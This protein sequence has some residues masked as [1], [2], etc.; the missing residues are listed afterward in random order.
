MQETLDLLSELNPCLD[1]SG[2]TLP[3]MS[4]SSKDD[5]AG[6]DST[7]AADG[8]MKLVMPQLVEGLRE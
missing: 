5:K 4:K 6:S 2:D 8:T 3:L 7:G 1:R